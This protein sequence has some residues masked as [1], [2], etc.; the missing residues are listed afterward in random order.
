MPEYLAPRARPRVRV[1]LDAEPEERDR[2][3][4]AAR[5]K[6]QSL[7]RWIRDACN[8]EAKA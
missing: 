1:Q 7:T 2:W 5:S 6:E 8:E 3:L 4:A